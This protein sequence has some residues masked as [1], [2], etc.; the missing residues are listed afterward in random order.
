MNISLKLNKLK[1]RS[2]V[3]RII[4]TIIFAT[5]YILLSSIKEGK[6]RFNELNFQRITEEINY[7]NEA[8]F[9]LSD[10][11]V[12]ATVFL[13]IAF[14]SYLH[15]NSKSIQDL[16]KKILQTNITLL[17]TYQLTRLLSLLCWPMREL[18]PFNSLYLVPIIIPISIL[19]TKIIQSL[20][21]HESGEM[22]IISKGALQ[23]ITITCGLTL[24]FLLPFFQ[25]YVK[26]IYLS[27]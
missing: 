7:K 27:P 13:L 4:I 8:V 19:K 15:G 17:P 24:L 23:I 6:I 1:K 11:L 16:F 26:K 25:S 3:I 12:I 14:F 20:T 18:I 21:Q 2:T 22:N 5:L 9:F 10:H